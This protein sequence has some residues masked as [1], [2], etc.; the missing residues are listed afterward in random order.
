MM[1]GTVAS[2]G[3]VLFE[4][5]LNQLL[6]YTRRCILAVDKLK[7][8]SFTHPSCLNNG[9]EG[10]WTTVLC[11]S[12]NVSVLTRIEMRQGCAHLCLEIMQLQGRVGPLPRA[13]TCVCG[14]IQM[15][16]EKDM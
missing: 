11:K 9:N 4:I 2:D 10:E 16:G 8:L 3:L 5:V 7:F 15:N 6:Y 12:S 14:V 1:L 13:T